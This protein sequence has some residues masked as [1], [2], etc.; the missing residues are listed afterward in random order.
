MGDGKDRHSAVQMKRK[1]V[2]LWAPDSLLTVSWC[3]K[4]RLELRAKL[5]ALFLQS[6]GSFKKRHSECPLELDW[7]WDNGP[8]K[9]GTPASPL[10]HFPELKLLAGEY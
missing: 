6:H 5:H 7:A 1:Y 9:G 8:G 10:C 2:I 3:F 4:I